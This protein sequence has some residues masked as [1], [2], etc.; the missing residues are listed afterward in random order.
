MSLAMLQFAFIR[1]KQKR[2][3]KVIATVRY[4]SESG[5]PAPLV[6]RRS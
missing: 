3:I 4:S 1:I 5:Q 6:F 2:A